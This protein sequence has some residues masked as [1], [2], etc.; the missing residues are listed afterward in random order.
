MRTRR[1]RLPRWLGALLAP[2]EDPRLSATQA[3]P[4]ASDLLAELRRSRAELA[5][6]R[7]Q[8]EQQAT[9]SAAASPSPPALLPAGEGRLRERLRELAEQEQELLEAE[10]RVRVSQEERR[11][12]EALERA[13]L[14]VLEAELQ[15]D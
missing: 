4:S 13:R 12:E 11:A 6:L 1:S 9:A 3:P 14:T 8:L 15:S 2:A 5:E 10:L 7:E